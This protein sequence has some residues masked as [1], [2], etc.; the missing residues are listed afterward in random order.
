MGFTDD[1]LK[2]LKEEIRQALALEN[3]VAM[4]GGRCKALFARL[5]AAEILCD[6]DTDD[7]EY[8]HDGCKRCKNTK[9]WRKSK[10]ETE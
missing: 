10:G 8:E 6:H 4:P 7:C 9:I 1:Y 5:E 2:R 3:S